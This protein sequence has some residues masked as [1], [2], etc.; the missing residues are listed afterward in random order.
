MKDS[1]LGFEVGSGLKRSQSKYSH[2]GICKLYGVK[3]KNNKMKYF[4]WYGGYQLTGNKPKLK[5]I[6]EASGAKAAKKYAKDKY[7]RNGWAEIR[8]PFSIKEAKKLGLIK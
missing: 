5:E 8:T 2:E 3:E 7:G 4:I 1:K 6:I